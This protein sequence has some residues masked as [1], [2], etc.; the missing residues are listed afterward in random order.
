[1]HN[2]KHLLIISIIIIIISMFLAY[3][4]V[5][6]KPNKY[7]NVGNLIKKI[8]TSSK[9]YDSDMKKHTSKEIFDKSNI[10]S[11]LN[12][13]YN[14]IEY[15]KPLKITT[16]N[17]REI[18]QHKINGKIF[19]YMSYDFDV[20][21]AVG[22]LVTASQNDPI[23]VTVIIRSNDKLYIEKVQEFEESPSEVPKIYR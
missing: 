13:Y 6:S 18:N 11:V 19:V 17:L 5:I 21:D 1:M 7:I 4:Y 3:D 14:G 20:H 16:F 15:K 12:K 8:Y 10:Y 2:K 22:K 9:G 23:V